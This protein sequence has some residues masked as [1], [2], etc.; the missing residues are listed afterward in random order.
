MKAAN[1]SQTIL[2]A[3][4]AVSFSDNSTSFAAFFALPPRQAPGGGVSSHGGS[5]AHY[6]RGGFDRGS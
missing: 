3:G 6:T 5:D 2:A 4:S 1:S